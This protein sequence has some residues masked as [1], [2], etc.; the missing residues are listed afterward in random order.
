MKVIFGVK[1]GRE[2]NDVRRGGK[3]KKLVHYYQDVMLFV[4]K[5]SALIS[6]KPSNDFVGLHPHL[7]GVKIAP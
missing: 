3:N 4:K 5:K 2:N 6:N 7:V 1:V